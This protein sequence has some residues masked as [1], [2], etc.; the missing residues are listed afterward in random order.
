MLVWT[1]NLKNNHKLQQIIQQFNDNTKEQAIK[2]I[3]EFKNDKKTKT[4][5]WFKWLK[6]SKT[7]QDLKL[8]FNIIEEES[9]WNEEGIK[10]PN[11]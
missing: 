4:R 1:E 10:K 9:N 7:I 8:I 2:E 11:N 5:G 6:P 3:K